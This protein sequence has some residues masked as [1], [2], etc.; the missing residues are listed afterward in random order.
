MDKD[1]KTIHFII[2]RVL[3]EEFY[4]HFSGRGEM[5]SFFVLMMKTAIEI[6]NQEN[7]LAK[8]VFKRIM[9]EEN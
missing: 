1:T 7:P 6:M 3:Y 9:E 4:R 5:K 8:E 2:P